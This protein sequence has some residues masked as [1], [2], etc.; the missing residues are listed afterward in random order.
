MKT[1]DT[2]LDFEDDNSEDFRLSFATRE[3]GDV[4]EEEYSDIDYRDAV[5]VK[6]ALINTFKDKINVDIETCDEWVLL[7]I[8]LE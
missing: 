5:R 3:N 2:T 6:K 8:T 1:L 7:S 4:C